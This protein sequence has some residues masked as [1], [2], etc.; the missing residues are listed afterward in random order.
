[1]KELVIIGIQVENEREEWRENENCESE[2]S[3][4]SN[5]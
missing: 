1:V 2:Y 4:Y 3:S 5:L